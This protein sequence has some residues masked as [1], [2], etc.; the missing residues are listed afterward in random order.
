MYLLAPFDV[1]LRKLL[2][3]WLI[4]LSLLFEPKF[5]KLSSCA[6]SCSFASSFLVT[7]AA[8]G[9]V[10]VVGALGR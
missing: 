2:W 6:C 3:W 4:L 5:F 1:L 9:D 8:A 10:V 7:V